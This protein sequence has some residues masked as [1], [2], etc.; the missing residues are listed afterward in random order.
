MKSAASWEDKQEHLKAAKALADF[1]NLDD[2]EEED[3][4]SFREAHPDF[5]PQSWWEYEPTNLQG[6][7]LPD[8]QWRI[9]QILVRDAWDS[10]FRIPPF[11][12]VLLLTAVFNPAWAKADYRPPYADASDLDEEYPYHRAVEWLTGQGWRAK[13]CLYCRKRFIA[14]HPK[15]QFCTFDTEDPDDVSDSGL[16]G[17]KIQCSMVYRKG[18]RSSWWNENKEHINLSRREEYQSKKSKKRSH[19]AKRK[20]LRQR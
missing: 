5:F 19:Y 10:N 11:E 1:A 9:A 18:Y 3:I 12:Y 14:E 4:K 6:V 20:N 16:E 2:D 13:T 17:R 8:S 15:R 7:P